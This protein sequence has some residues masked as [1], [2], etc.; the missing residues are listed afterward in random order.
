[1]SDGFTERRTSPRVPYRFAAEWSDH[2]YEWSGDALNVGPGGCFVV[3][4]PLAQAK[5]LRV[6]LALPGQA[7]FVVD[8]TVAHAAADGMGLAFRLPDTGAFAR[9]ADAFERLV[10]RD[11]ELAARVRRFMPRL[12]PGV[13]LY[14]TPRAARTGA[15]R[16]PDERR[17]LRLAGT[18]ATV[19]DLRS[20]GGAGLAHAVFALLERDLLTTIQ[21]RGT[22]GVSTVPGEA[23]APAPREG[24]RA[25]S[26]ERYFRQAQE[27]LQGGNAPAAITALRL[28]LALCPGDPQIEAELARLGA[29]V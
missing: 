17:A 4:Q 11:P 23:P 19:R 15:A 28:A 20:R 13:R 3:G 6:A 29:R 27:H 7:P 2:F 8:A 18:G 12:E 14:P 26:A 10:V 1:M 16:T 9:S 25:P 24:T 22:Q 21:G 5:I